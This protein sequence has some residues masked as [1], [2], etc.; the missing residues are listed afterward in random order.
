MA[1]VREGWNRKIPGDLKEPPTKE[2]NVT[3]SYICVTDSLRL[4][5]SNFTTNIS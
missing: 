5:A 1:M 2:L 3:C 4:K